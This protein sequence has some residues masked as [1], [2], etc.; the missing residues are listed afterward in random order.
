[1]TVKDVYRCTVRGGRLGIEVTSRTQ[2]IQSIADISPRNLKRISETSYHNFSFFENL[3]FLLILTAGKREMVAV[4]FI[5]YETAHTRWR[6]ARPK[7]L[8]KCVVSVS[9]KQRPKARWTDC[10][11][12]CRLAKFRYLMIEGEYGAVIG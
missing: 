2:A 5:F 4:R 11:L 6:S 7:A 12:H 9:Y 1:V 10:S 8:I 3:V